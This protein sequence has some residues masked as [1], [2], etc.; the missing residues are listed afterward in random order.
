MQ[1]L[2]FAEGVLEQRGKLFRS[3]QGKAESLDMVMAM[4]EALSRNRQSHRHLHIRHNTISVYRKGPRNLPSASAF[5][6]P[7]PN[8]LL[9]SHLEHIAH[10]PRIEYMPEAGNTKT[11]LAVCCSLRIHEHFRLG[12]FGCCAQTGMSSLQ[13]MLSISP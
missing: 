4:T 13:L 10:A 2:L 1:E 6:G 9:P 3:D 11:Q 12:I 7:V 8:L 5:G